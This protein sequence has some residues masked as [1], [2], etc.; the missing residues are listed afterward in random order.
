MSSSDHE[1]PKAGMIAMSPEGG[2]VLA[3]RRIASATFVAVGS[4]TERVPVSVVW[5]TYLLVPV[6]EWH[7]AHMLA[8][9]ASPLGFASATTPSDGCSDANS[10]FGAGRSG[11]DTGG[12][13]RTYST[14]AL[15]S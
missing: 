5:G 7:P 11:V 1:G 10:S 6:Q 4:F 12:I 9:I 8:N 13:V 14:I 2:S 15:T 3:P